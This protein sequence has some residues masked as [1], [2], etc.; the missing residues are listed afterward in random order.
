MI[1]LPLLAMSTKGGGGIIRALA[2][3][4]ALVPQTGLFPV[5]VIQ[6]LSVFSNMS[7]MN[8]HVGHTATLALVSNSLFSCRDS[9]F[10]SKVL[11]PDQKLIKCA[12]VF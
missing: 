8:H 4:F 3:A 7:F 11:S 1:V 5:L 10:T 6:S 12:N 9:T 2:L